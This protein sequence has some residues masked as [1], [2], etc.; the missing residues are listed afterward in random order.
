MFNN[1]KNYSILE[2]GGDHKTSVVFQKGKKNADVKKRKHSH[3]CSELPVNQT[4]T[5]IYPLL[6]WF[7]NL[8]HII[9]PWRDFPGSSTTICVSVILR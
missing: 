5:Y 1:G 7:S 9:I 6:H 2:Q 8:A 3:T 4:F